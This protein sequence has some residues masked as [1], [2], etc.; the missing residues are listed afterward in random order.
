[1]GQGV[2]PKRYH[3]LTEQLSVAQLEQFMADL[4]QLTRHTVQQMPSHAQWLAR[5]ATA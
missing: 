5:F 4:R 2:R 3:A 1:M